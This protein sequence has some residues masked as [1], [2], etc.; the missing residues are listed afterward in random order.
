MFA[1]IVLSLI[2][3]ASVAFYA[4]LGSPRL[5]SLIKEDYKTNNEIKN[6]RI[7]TEIRTLILERL[8]IFLHEHTHSRPRVPYSW[9][10]SDSNFVVKAFGKLSVTKSLNYNGASLF[11]SQDAFAAAKRIGYGPIQLWLSGSAQVD[12]YECVVSLWPK[13]QPY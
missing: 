11:R 13:G 4:E 1:L 9:L 12:M 2:T 10:N 7:P 5:S 8:P 3:T 6:S